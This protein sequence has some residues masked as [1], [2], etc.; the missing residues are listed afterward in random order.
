M[1]SVSAFAI[2]SLMVTSFAQ[3]AC[4]GSTRCE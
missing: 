3:V 2:G 4:T 1:K